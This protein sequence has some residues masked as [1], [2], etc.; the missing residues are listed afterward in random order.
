MV[1]FFIPKLRSGLCVYVRKFWN[2]SEREKCSAV[3]AIIGIS[4]ALLSAFLLPVDV[5]LVSFMKNSDGSFKEWA[6]NSTR[7]AVEDS[8]TYTYYSLYGIIFF[9]AFFVLPLSYFSYEEHDEDERNSYGVFTIALLYTFIFLFVISGLLLAGAFIPYKA[10]P[11][12]NSTEWDKIDF[13]IKELSKSK[14]K[15]AV[16]F[17]VNVLTLYGMLN[18]ILYTSTGLTSF[19]VALIKGFRSLSEEESILSQN[20]ASTQSKI[21]AL[22]SKQA[23]KSLSSREIATLAQLEEE[24]SLLSRRHNLLESEKRNIFNKC[25]PFF[26]IINVTFGC[27]GISFSLVLFISLLISN[28][29][30]LMNS[31][32]YKMGYVLKE[33]LLPNILDYIMVRAQKIF[34][35]DYVLFFLIVI[36]LV[37]C[38]VS[39]MRFMGIC[40]L[41]VPMYKVRPGRTPPQA[42]IMLSFLL[43][44]VVL[45]I[46]VLMHSLIPSYTT[47][48]SQ[49][50]CKFTNGTCDLTAC[51]LDAKEDECL[52][53]RAGAFILSFAYQAWIFSAAYFW[54]T[55]VFLA[56]FAVNFVYVLIRSR[57]SSLE[58]AID[59][60]DF[61]DSD[62]PMITI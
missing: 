18:I 33:N 28:I 46:N 11:P 22:R 53:T 31:L 62:D 3:V 42:L 15:D 56:A 55:W 49:Y 40:C 57:R 25:Q 4:I 2:R 54:L 17:V 6:T 16:A 36:F 44:F 13:L 14:G 41:C 39:G 52:M 9:Y 61:D 19:P 32:G 21:N 5:F 37:I 24:E 23:R 10:E 50:Y 60:D 12:Q 59:R 58:E 8:V 51:S 26:R 20:Q 47:F 27:I 43:M 34:P 38:T 48:G 45:A 30:K 29:D 7:Q 1:F 35:M